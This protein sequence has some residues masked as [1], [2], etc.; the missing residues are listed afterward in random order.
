MSD[1]VFDALQN[2]LRALKGDSLQ[3]FGENFV[4]FFLFDASIPDL[5]LLLGVCS[6]EDDDKHHGR[7]AS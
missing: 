1:P 5:S 3:R 2:E 4:G 6:E 7:I